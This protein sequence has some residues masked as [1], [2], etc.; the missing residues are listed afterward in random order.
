MQALAV[1]SKQRSS[2]LPNVPSTAELG[3]P[4]VDLEIWLS[5]TAPKGVPAEARLRLSAALEQMMKS[6]KGRAHASQLGFE[7]AFATSTDWAGDVTRELAE[8][9]AVARSAGIKEE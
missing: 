8:M 4:S 2:H 5:V 3:Y 9:R 1:L 7:P 6:E